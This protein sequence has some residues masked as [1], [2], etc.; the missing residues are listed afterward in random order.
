MSKHVA[1]LRLGNGVAEGGRAPLQRLELQVL[2]CVICEGSTKQICTFA[3]Q[4]RVEMPPFAGGL[5]LSLRLRRLSSHPA[6]EPAGFENL[7]LEIF[8]APTRCNSP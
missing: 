1:K 4:E 7:V 8:R 5:A 2:F 6:L 3:G